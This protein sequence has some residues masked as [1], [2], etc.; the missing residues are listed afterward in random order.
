MSSFAFVSL[1]CYMYMY[2]CLKIYSSVLYIFQLYK[3]FFILQLAL[4]TQRYFSKIYSFMI[5]SFI[6]FYCSI[7]S[8]LRTYH[9]LSISLL[10]DIGMFLMFATVIYAVRNIL[11]CFWCI[12][13]KVYLGYVLGSRNTDLWDKQM[14]NYFLKWL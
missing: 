11:V 8:I 13:A 14:L 3:N 4:F 9:N 6:H 12:C 5:L 2:G 7:H 10:M 1:F